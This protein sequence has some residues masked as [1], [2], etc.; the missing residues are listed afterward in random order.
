MLVWQEATLLLCKLTLGVSTLLLA[1]GTP[2]VVVGPCI[3][4]P[5]AAASDS[6][7]RCP[8]ESGKGGCLGQPVLG[9]WVSCY[10]GSASICT[11]KVLTAEYCR[12]GTR[13][14]KSSGACLLEQRPQPS[15]LT[16]GD[17]P[18]VR[19]VGPHTTSSQQWAADLYTR[20]RHPHVPHAGHSAAQVPPAAAAH[21]P[22]AAASACAPP[23]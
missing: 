10:S 17:R 3:G 8:H 23:A 22:K 5:H 19:F 15:V 21:K 2:D 7:L 14:C 13:L 12:V 20:Q 11:V 18:L 16:A 1:A 6:L 4:L 9:S